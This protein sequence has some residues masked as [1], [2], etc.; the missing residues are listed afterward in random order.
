MSFLTVFCVR[1]TGGEKK[2]I[3]LETVL[4]GDQKRALMR[5]AIKCCHQ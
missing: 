1:V 2:S 4:W 5:R 3:A